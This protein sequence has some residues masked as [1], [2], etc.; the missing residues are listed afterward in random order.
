MCKRLTLLL[1]FTFVVVSNCSVKPK[2]RSNPASPAV[3]IPDKKPAIKFEVPEELKNAKSLKT[4]T[5]KAS[6]YGEPFHGRKTANG[7]VYDMYKSS[8]AHKDLP[9]GTWVRVTN[10]NNN[11]QIITRINDRGPFIK[12]RI[13]DLSYGAA[14]AIDMVV[15]GV[16][17]I[18]LE[19]L[20]YGDGKY[21]KLLSAVYDDI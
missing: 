2:Y 11:K 1:I 18:K 17:E 10:L 12:G 14:L 20:K 5:G 6:W 4:F 15:D 13:L 9:T 19:V 16:V 7:E 21:Y 3:R 8:A